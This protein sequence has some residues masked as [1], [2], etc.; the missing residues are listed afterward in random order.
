MPC[1]VRGRGFFRRADSFAY[2]SRQG[3]TSCQLRLIH[4]RSINIW[5]RYPHLDIPSKTLFNIHRA[6]A[7]P[8]RCGGEDDQNF[9]SPSGH[10]RRPVRRRRYCMIPVWHSDEQC[11]IVTMKI[12][13]L[14][15]TKKILD[16]LTILCPYTKIPTLVKMSSYFLNSFVKKLVKNKR[17]QCWEKLHSR[18]RAQIHHIQKT[19]KK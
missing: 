17:T 12:L 13:K 2:I 5:T 9:Q 8:L 6:S 15:N 19:L 1:K 3:M 16:S 10:L 4:S 7:L 14:Q 18:A 11:D